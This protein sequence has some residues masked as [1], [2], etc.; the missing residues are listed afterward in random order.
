MKTTDVQELVGRLAAVDAGC[1]D[2]ASLRV[3][4]DDVRRLRSWVDGREVAVARIVAEVSSFPEK[5]LAEAGRTSLRHGEQVLKRA[6]TVKTVPELGA[7]LS[8]G[9]VSGEHV[10][11]MGRVL[12]Q[13][14]PAVRQELIDAVPNL[15]LIAENTSADEFAK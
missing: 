6:E 12:R 5:S 3:A 10:D 11:V 2:W 1:A 7:S 13:L 4:V 8:A 9:R 14:D 15:V